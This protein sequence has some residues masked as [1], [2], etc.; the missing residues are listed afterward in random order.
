MSN[1][2]SC[3]TRLVAGPVSVSEAVRRCYLTDYPS[4]DIEPEFFELYRSN[5]GLLQR[6]L[7]TRGSIEIMSGEGMVALWG[8]LKST[9]VPGDRVLCVSSGLFGDGFV[10]MARACGAETRLVKG[11]EGDCPALDDVRAALAEFKPKAVTFV[12]CE[13]PAGMLNE[14]AS[15]GKL[16][17]EAGALFL[18][19]FVSAVGGVEVRVDDWN[20]DIGMLGSQKCLS[21]LPD[22]SVVSVSERAWKVIEE[23]DYKGYDAIKQFK[24]AL[25]RGELPYTP[26]WHAHAALN[27]ALQALFDEG[28]ENVF[29]RHREVAQAAREGVRALGLKTYPARE[30]LNSPTVTAV[31][32]PEGWTWPE[33][34]AKLRERGV[35]LC[36]SWGDLAGKVF[37][38]G[39]MG[40]QCRMETVK[41]ALEVLG[42]VLATRRE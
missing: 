17:A 23:V 10:D 16:C 38:I 26:C 24:G 6:L 42:Q 28:L 21:C 2:E 7:N 27:T 11:P 35:M 9:I 14:V 8:A 5:Q 30:E 33:L 25:E 40:N 34:N 1:Y 41:R 22:L 32:V 36:G 29:Q 39:H 4:G 31:Y 15:V 3:H 13:T 20:I 37:R 12:M 18:V 19:D